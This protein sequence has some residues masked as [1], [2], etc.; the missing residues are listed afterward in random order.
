MKLG[1]SASKP[2][3]SAKRSGEGIAE[4]VRLYLTNPTRVSKASP[5]LAHFKKSLDAD[6]LS[7]LATLRKNISYQGLPYNKRIWNISSGESRRLTR[8]H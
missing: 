2:G 6:T 8:I 3:Y 1:V 7:F 4:F 5:V